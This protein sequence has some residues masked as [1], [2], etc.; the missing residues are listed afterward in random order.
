MALTPDRRVLLQFL[1]RL[2]QAELAAGNA[3]A[4]VERDLGQIAK[5][6]G[7]VGMTASVLPTAL[8]IQFDEADEH[9]L[10]LTLG[11][12]RV[13]DLRFDQVEGVLQVAREARAGTL[14]PTDGLRRLDA[15]WRMRHRYGD[16]G[17]V[18]GYLITTVGVGLMLRPSW[19]ALGLVA[20]LGLLCALLLVAVRRQPA[21]N[22]VMP[23]VAAFLLSAAVG[24]AH[25]A[26]MRGSAMDLLIPPL[27]VFLPGS[28]LTVAVVELAFANIVS[29]ATRLV[30]GFTQLVLLAFGLLGGFRLF[31]PPTPDALQHVPDRLAPWLPWLGVLLFA[32][33]LHLYKSSRPRSL[34]WMTFTM[35]MAY[36]GQTLSG[37]VFAGA[38]TAF[39]G[40]VVM[41]LTA[42]L[43]EYRFKGPPAL[44]TFLPAFWLLAPGAFGLAS[45]AGMATNAGG[46][47]HNIL[48]L[49]FT[50]TA[51]AM[52]CLIGAFMY[53][54]LFHV[55][56]AAWWR[57]GAS[58]LRKDPEAPD[59]FP[60]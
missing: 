30:A 39:F 33:G 52:G 2:G 7:M 21:W 37:I 47:A 9:S 34:L 24:L 49:L 41:T 40:A 27:V 25:D 36:A 3:A 23:V 8:F 18:A 60:V 19:Q 35:A 22:A 5:R 38:S 10:R 46:T 20:A 50:L 32:L 58:G 42:L 48:Q 15:I 1:S 59:K 29:G 13:G 55:R 12:Y 6:N 54:G 16:V 11:P 56:R 57:Y 44:V 17:F 45:V 26:G 53:S 43:I 28:M 31:G 51:I 14:S 4:L